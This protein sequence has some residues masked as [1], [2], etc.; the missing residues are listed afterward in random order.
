MG[1]PVIIEHPATVLVVG[2][3][4]SGKT[5]FILQLIKYM[6]QL[7]SPTPERIVYCYGLWQSVFDDYKNRV[8]FRKGYNEEEIKFN[9]K[10]RS[11]VILDDIMLEAMGSHSVS[12][13]FTKGSHHL[14]VSVFLLSQNLYCQ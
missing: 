2:P 4:Q 9:P 3:T 7:I 13:L 12:D 6:N 10:Q 1:H 14:N 5:F 11:L 8:E